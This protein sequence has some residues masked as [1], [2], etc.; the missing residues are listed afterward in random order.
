MNEQRSLTEL[1][2]LD[3]RVALVTGAAAGIGLAIVRRFVEA[4][5]VVHAVDRSQ[6]AVAVARDELAD[7]PVRWHECD[8]T[9]PSG[10]ADVVEAT[11]ADGGVDVLVNNAGVFPNRLLLDCDAAAWRDLAAVNI[12]GV[13]NFLNPAARLMIEHGRGGSIVNIASVAGIKASTLFAHYGATKA[14]VINISNA[15]AAELGKH[16]IRVN[17]V[18]PGGI[19]TPGFGVAAAQAQANAAAG[20]APAPVAGRPIGRLG[21]PDDVALAAAYLAS[22]LASY[23]TGA[24]L[25]V[26]GG[27]LA[28]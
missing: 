21:T 25:V 15:A 22:D 8:V 4:G 12:E 24:T 9:D 27:A 2:R 1:G 11:R 7:S 20:V 26:D 23:V 5:A 28:G 3:G 10:A 19:V 16:G 13:L 18:A 6:A 14:A 17:A